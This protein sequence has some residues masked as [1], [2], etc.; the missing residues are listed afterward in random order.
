[1]S[2]VTMQSLQEDI[3]SELKD[4]FDDFYEDRC[5]DFAE[6]V[7]GHIPVYNCDLLSALQ[8]DHSLASVDDRGLLPENP[9]VYD[10]IRM[11]MYEQLRSYAY[12]EFQRLKEEFDEFK[13]DM[14]LEDYGIEYVGKGVHHIYKGADEAT[15]IKLH[16]ADSEYKCWKWL[17]DNPQDDEALQERIDELEE[18]VKEKQNDSY[19]VLYRRGDIYELCRHEVTFHQADT[20]QACWVWL[21][22]NPQNV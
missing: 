19:E 6:L 18:F 8:S 13:E 1:M 2:D 10:I 9:D 16:E 4:R 3:D 17:Q 7:D 22:E 20:E 21:K 12:Q 14:E 5:P 15:R 11:A